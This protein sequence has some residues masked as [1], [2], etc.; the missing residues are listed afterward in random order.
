[1]KKNRELII[2]FKNLSLEEH[3][4]DFEIG[5]AFFESYEF[6]D[7]HEGRV[8]LSVD[9][10]KE[11]SLMVLLF[12][13]DGRVILS[14]DRCL[15]NYSQNL[16]G[17]F[18]LIVKFAEKFEEVSDE[19]ITLPHEE[20]QVD[21]RQYIYE[22]INL[23]IP[24]KRVHPDDENGNSTCQAEMLDRLEKLSEHIDDPRWDALKKIG[25]K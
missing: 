23:M 19:L 10:E 24:I 25:I 5:D 6:L 16:T 11:A 7:V 21:L 13:F 14:C 4:Y 22:Y 8:R 12:H 9:L 20:S 15:E 1:M 3:H 2:S 17:N 18:R